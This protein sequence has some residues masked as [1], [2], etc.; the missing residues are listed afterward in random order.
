[1]F[2]DKRAESNGKRILFTGGSGKAGVK[3]RKFD[4][5]NIQKT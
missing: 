2:T 3:R 5:S 1:M 4:A